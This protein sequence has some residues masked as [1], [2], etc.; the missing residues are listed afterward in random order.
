M[1][2]AT[3]ETVK[4]TSNWWALALRAV[5][6]ILLG[7]IALM[8]PGV[9]LAAIITLFGVFAMADG[10][11]AIVAALRGIKHHT[12]WGWM[13][14]EGIVGI[15]AGA[16]ALLYPAIG[17]L[18]LA[19]LIGGWALATGVLEIA[20]A[21]RLRKVMKREWLLLLGGVLSIIFALIVAFR[22]GISVLLLVMWVGI[23]AL[24]HGLVTLALAFRVRR[25]SRDN[26]AAP[27]PV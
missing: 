11:F 16:I 4:E 9:T 6:A 8:A 26:A 3:V 5:A 21:I 13:L 14:F 25:W 10:I 17:A 7:L 18:A 2:G 24:A 1:M 12:R 23:F 19:W 22:P 27:A 20:A 15:A